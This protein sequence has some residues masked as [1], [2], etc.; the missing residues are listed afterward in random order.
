MRAG[1]IIQHGTLPERATGLVRCDIGACIGFLPRPQWPEEATGGDFLEIKIRRYEELAEHPQRGFVEP[2]VRRAARSFFEN[3]G[4]TLYVY[5]VCIDDPS[6]LVGGGLAEG[7]LLPLFERLRTEEEIALICVPPL[8]YMKCEVS[9]KGEVRWHGDALADELLAHC[10]QMN[11]RFLV[12][13]APRGLHGDLLS[14][15]FEAFRRRDPLTRAYGAV[16]YPWLMQGD[17]LYAPSGAVMGTFARVEL[18]HS[19]MGV[20]WPPANVAVRGATHTDI[21]IDWAEAGNVGDAGI[22]PLV[23]QPGRG[24]VIWGARTM[25][26][27][28][29]WVHI[30]SRRVVSMVTE[31]LRRDNEWA[32]FEPNDSSLWK[33]I[34]RDVLVRLEQFW[35]AGLLSGTRAREE[36][37]VECNRATNPPAIRDRGEL[38]VS[39]QLKPVGTT[40]RI[41][42]DLRLG[43]NGP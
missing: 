23:V 37:S 35:S 33:V 34:E 2:C 19:P 8:A 25:S 31:Q 26:L 9:R 15:W 27:D 30:N 1:L 36:Y 17:E 29:A 38:H 4:D 14:R 13:D 11:N 41:L 3:G 42:I 22:N 20:G 21:E 5:A 39:V 12:L 18:E 6:V 7:P 24:V 32:V 43:T 16:Y 40:E 10:R 28:P